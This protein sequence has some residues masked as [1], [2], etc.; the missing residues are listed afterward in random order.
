ML[1][2]AVLGAGLQAY[3]RYG[4]GVHAETM[5]VIAAQ[6]LVESF[7]NYN[8]GEINCLEIS[9]LNFQG[10]I[11]LK[12]LLKFFIKGGP[13]HCVNM[14]VKYGPLAF[15]DINAVFTDDIKEM[16]S[17]PVSCAALLA[18]KM[19]V[20]DLHTTMVAGFAGGI[21]LSG[22]GCGALGAAIWMNSLKSIHSGANNKS[23]TTDAGNLINEFIKGTEY[24]LECSEIVGRKFTS[25]ADH[26]RYLQDG[27][28]AEI[29]EFLVKKTTGG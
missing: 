19:G 28:C 11:E 5:S 9:E 6:K 26:A 3:Q 20:S 12:P 1:W 23:I 29:I 21:G 2:G 13:V 16:P 14:A 27:G 18:Q 7:I 25:V 8:K 10:N 4:S 17:P 22:S 24:K 15:N